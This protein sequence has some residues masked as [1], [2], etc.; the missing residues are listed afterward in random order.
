MLYSVLIIVNIHAVQYSLFAC[1]HLTIGIESIKWKTSTQIYLH[2]ISD[3]ISKIQ[4]V[5]LSNQFNN[6]IKI[7]AQNK[8][9]IVLSTDIKSIYTNSKCVVPNIL[10]D[11]FLWEKQCMR[12]IWEGDNKRLLFISHVT[13]LIRKSSRDIPSNV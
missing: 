3:F 8:L 9:Q 1:V 4:F 7:L 10:V 6:Q 13:K 12:I 11:C 2:R 5:C